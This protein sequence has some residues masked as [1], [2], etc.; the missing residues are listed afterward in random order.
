MEVREGTTSI[1]LQRK[2]HP[3]TSAC[4]I[5]QLAPRIIFHSIP[6]MPMALAHLPDYILLT[7]PCFQKFNKLPSVDYLCLSLS[8]M[9]EIS[10]QLFC[11]FSG[12]R[13]GGPVNNHAWSAILQSW[14]WMHHFPGNQDKLFY[15]VF[16]MFYLILRQTLL[17]S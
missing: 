10:R 5:C 13:D 4:C 1:V 9:L 15:S 11:Y 3:L 6:Y 12:I 17:F 14:T 7:F 2:L 8:Y 16:S